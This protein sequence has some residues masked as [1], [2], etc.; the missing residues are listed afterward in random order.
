M[1]VRKGFT[2]VE[3]LV[4]VMMLGVLAAI[5]VPRLS[6]GALRRQKAQ[7][8]ARKIVADLRLAR[9]L[10]ITNAAT[11]SRGFELNL[12]GHAPYSRYEIKDRDGGTVVGT[13]TIDAAVV[14]RGAG[15]F[16]F[17]P[18]GNLTDGDPDEMW[19]TL[20]ADGKTVTIT[21]VPATGM[22]KCE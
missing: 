6:V 20:A 22:V 9:Q 5:A 21:V 16:R 15:R 7:S 19:L 17:G 18:L 4:V 1:W 12:I 10:A 14:C 2:L 11:N 8:E 3:V 13:Y